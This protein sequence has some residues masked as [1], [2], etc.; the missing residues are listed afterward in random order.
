MLRRH[1]RYVVL[2]ETTGLYHR[3]AGKIYKRTEKDTTLDIIS[4]I[5][6]V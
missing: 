3:K 6:K 2:T 5:C 1:P 4:E